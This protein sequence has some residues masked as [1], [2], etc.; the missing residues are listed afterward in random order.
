MSQAST[1]E[2]P[3]PGMAVGSADPSRA[4]AGGDGCSLIEDLSMALVGSGS[5]VMLAANPKAAAFPYSHPGSS[6][7]LIRPILEIGRDV[8]IWHTREPLPGRDDPVG[9]GDLACLFD[10]LTRRHPAQS[11][12]VLLHPLAPWGREQAWGLDIGSWPQDG[13]QPEASRLVLGQGP[14]GWEAVSWYLKDLS[15]K[16]EFFGDLRQ[17]SFWREAL[18]PFSFRAWLTSAVQERFPEGE[19]VSIW[20]EAWTRF[21]NSGVA[22]NDQSFSLLESRI[23]GADPAGQGDLRILAKAWILNLPQPLK[24]RPWGGMAEA[25]PLGALFRR[26]WR[27]EDFR[28]LAAHPQLHGQV[29]AMAQVLPLTAAGVREAR[30]RAPPIAG[31]WVDH[32]ASTALRQVVW[33]AVDLSAVHGLDSQDLFQEGIMGAFEAAQSYQALGENGGFRP[34]VSFANLRIWHKVEHYCLANRHLIQQ[35][36]PILP[37]HA[38]LMD[39]SGDGGMTV[40]DVLTGGGIGWPRRPGESPARVV[41]L[42]GPETSQGYGPLEGLWQ[43]ELRAGVR[44]LL[45]SLKEQEEE[46]L[47]R[48]FGVADDPSKV[49][50]GQSYLEVGRAFS[51]SGQRIRQIEAKAFVRLRDPRYRCFMNA[52]L[53]LAEMAPLPPSGAFS[54]TQMMPKP[55]PPAPSPKKTRARH[56]KYP[57]PSRSGC[58]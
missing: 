18:T 1:P 50:E 57:H 24:A 49:L 42:V 6:Q 4:G 9:A 19:A 31:P 12:H 46:V 43:R 55:R 7:T 44:I 35:G 13:M 3:L 56:A 15:A 10:E 2:K 41:D 25:D 52:L 45:Q 36:V 53:A 51:L 11:L 23:P 54:F 21:G 8:W 40:A 58:R 48:R 16:C 14:A 30:R 38:D 39:P 33:T 28:G 5:A 27:L 22:M 47:R 20:T 17:R 26:A 29:S 34:F 37:L 32:L